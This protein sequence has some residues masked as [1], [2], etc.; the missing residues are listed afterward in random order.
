MLRVTPSSSSKAV[1]GGRASLF[2]LK[3][4]VGA[5]AYPPGGLQLS[6]V[7]WWAAGHGAV[8]RPTCSVMLKQRNPTGNPLPLD[9]PLSRGFGDFG[10]SLTPIA[11]L[12]PRGPQGLTEAMSRKQKARGREAPGKA[13]CHLVLGQASRGH[14]S[15]R[16]NGGGMGTPPIAHRL[17]QPHQRVAHPTKPAPAPCASAMGCLPCHEPPGLFLGA[18]I[19]IL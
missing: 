12:A 14:S 18:N 13:R 4:P 15:P 9:P 7:A 1:P 5:H 11:S 2:G 3:L 6:P 10:H 17:Y 19:L 16:N 8:P